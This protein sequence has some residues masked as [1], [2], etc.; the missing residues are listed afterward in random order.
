MI[1]RVDADS[2]VPPYE[3]LRRQIA[4]S[5]AGGQLPAGHQLPPIRQLAADLELAPGT[6]ARAYRELET[7]GLVVS[8]GRRG[9]RV[10]EAPPSATADEVTTR[11]AEAAAELATVAQALG[12][13]EPATIAAVR[14]AMADREAG[15]PAASASVVAP[16]PRADPI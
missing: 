9:T 6:V 11:L 8:H 16:V 12:V 10:V 3:Q 14:Q 13:D 1:V 15:R 5:I 4:T 7:A 2:P